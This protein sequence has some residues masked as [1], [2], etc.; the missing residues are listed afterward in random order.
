[1]PG[2]LKDEEFIMKNKT[3]VTLSPFQRSY[4]PA[5]HLKNAL[6]AP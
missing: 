4:L 6:A 2:L 3:S 1:M 5:L